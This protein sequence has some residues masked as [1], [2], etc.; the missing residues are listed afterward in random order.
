MRQTGG[1]GIEIQ[2]AACLLLKA[3]R[4]GSD[5]YDGRVSLLTH[6]NV[7][8]NSGQPTIKVGQSSI[9]MYMCVRIEALCFTENCS[10]LCERDRLLSDVEP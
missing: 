8:A 4:S 3:P 7:I 9:Y 6:D 5:V 1:N 2:P 10:R